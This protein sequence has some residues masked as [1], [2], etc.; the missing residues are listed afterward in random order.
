VNHPRKRKGR[1]PSLSR[2]DEDDRPICGPPVVEEFPTD[3]GNEPL[4]R[5]KRLAEKGRDRRYLTSCASA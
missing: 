4:P 3:I 1:F 2:D 5:E